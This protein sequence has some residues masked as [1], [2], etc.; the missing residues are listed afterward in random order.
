M[1]AV[2]WMDLGQM[3]FH[4][5]IMSEGG[6]RATSPVLAASNLWAKSIQ[7]TEH[8]LQNRVPER[9]FA[10]T[11]MSVSPSTNPPPSRVPRVQAA[12]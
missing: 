12:R 1:A 9:S 10:S 11:K 4:R 7:R 2:L 3:G 6:E 8:S 5:Q